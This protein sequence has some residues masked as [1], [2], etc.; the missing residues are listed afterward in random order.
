MD[1]LVQN[2]NA[3]LVNV[4]LIVGFHLCIFIASLL[5]FFAEIYNIIDEFQICKECFEEVGEFFD[6]HPARLLVGKI[7]TRLLKCFEFP[8][9]DMEVLDMFS[10]FNESIEFFIIT[11]LQIFEILN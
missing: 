5:V 1:H 11:F 7:K 4:S 3:I 8:D 10:D 6:C 2:V 9:V